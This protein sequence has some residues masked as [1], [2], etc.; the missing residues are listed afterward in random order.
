MADKVTVELSAEYAEHLKLLKQVI[1]SSTW[2]EITDD[3][4]M[5]EALIDSFMSFIQEQAAAH[6]H[7]EWG[8]CCGWEWHVHGHSHWSEGGC[9]SK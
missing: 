3:G 7:A 9:C 4:K 2:E 6:Q 5:V 1:P 8:W